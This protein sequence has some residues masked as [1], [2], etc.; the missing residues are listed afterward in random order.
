[1]GFYKN[2]DSFDPLIIDSNCGENKVFVFYFL[3]NPGQ[4]SVQFEQQ[5]AQRLAFPLYRVKYFR[6]DPDNLAKIIQ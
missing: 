2:P 3:T 6:I 5:A 1:L 4:L